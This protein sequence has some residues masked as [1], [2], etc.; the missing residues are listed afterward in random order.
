MDKLRAEVASQNPLDALQHY[1][2][3]LHTDEV[4]LKLEVWSGCVDVRL[5]PEQHDGEYLVCA[6]GTL[7][8]RQHLRALLMQPVKGS[9]STLASSVGT[10]KR[11][12]PNFKL[13]R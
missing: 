6:R 1:A 5:C 2:R 12:H 7:R 13:G 4:I 9:W 3:Q 8:A 11:A 10:F